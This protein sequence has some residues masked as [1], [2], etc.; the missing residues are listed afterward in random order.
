[1][2]ACKLT[3][4]KAVFRRGLAALVLLS[5]F[6]S[7]DPCRAQDAGIREI[8]IPYGLSWG[9]APEKIRDMI[10]AVKAHELSDTQVTPG[11]TVIEA[12]G[13]GVGDPLLKKSL[14]TFRDGALVEVELQYANETWDADKSVDFFD[15]TRRRIDDRYGAGTLM[16]NK[17][18]DVP[19]GDNLPKDLT[20][21]MII[22]RWTQPMVALELNFYSMEENARAYR[23]VSLHYKT[24]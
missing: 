7:S 4:L 12:E 22:Y 1:M 16:V 9:D 20:Y 15:R 10:T 6:S 24:P 21:T 11:K 13:L 3:K 5:A 18:K 19:P 14:F 2:N 23:I 17:V 8:K